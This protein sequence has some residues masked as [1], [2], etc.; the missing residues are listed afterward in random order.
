MSKDQVGKLVNI[1]LELNALKKLCPTINNHVQS[2]NDQLGKLVNCHAWLKEVKKLSQ[3]V[4]IY[5]I[6]NE[7]FGKLIRFQFLLKYSKK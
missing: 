1:Q 6:S 4:V 7:F 2:L 5:D 3:T